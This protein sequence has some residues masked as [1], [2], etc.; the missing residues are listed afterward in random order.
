MGSRVAQKHD[1]NAVNPPCMEEQPLNSLLPPGLLSVLSLSIEQRATGAQP[2]GRLP[3]EQQNSIDV[4]ANA[5]RA[6]FQGRPSSVTREVEQGAASS[7]RGEVVGDNVSN[8]QGREYAVDFGSVDGDAADPDFARTDFSAERLP[9]ELFSAERF[10]KQFPAQR[11][12]WQDK[13]SISAQRLPDEG[14]GTD[15]I[16]AQR[17]LIPEFAGECLGTLSAHTE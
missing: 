13:N 3:R 1:A 16:S 17:L 7:S 6:K 5:A 8:E 15:P 9:I 14:V 4:Y 12:P 10:P 2:E 11:L